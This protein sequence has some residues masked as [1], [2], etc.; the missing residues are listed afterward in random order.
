V[1][2]LGFQEKGA[3]IRLRRVSPKGNAGA[4]VT[5]AATSA[6][7]SAGFPRSA[8]AG[9]RLWLAWVEDAPG[10]EASSRV[11]AASLPLSA[12]R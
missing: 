12:V 11:R 6:A 3:A 8:V 4:P 7:R 2:W 10:E 9:D 5:I 1:S